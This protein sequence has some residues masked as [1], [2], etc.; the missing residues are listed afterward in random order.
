MRYLDAGKVNHNVMIF[1]HSDLSA[2]GQVFFIP[3]KDH[4]RGSEDEREIQDHG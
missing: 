4:K 2:Y 1:K 3:V